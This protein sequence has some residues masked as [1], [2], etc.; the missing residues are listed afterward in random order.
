MVSVIWAEGASTVAMALGT[1]ST[2]TRVNDGVEVSMMV[3]GDWGRFGV[4]GE[5][6]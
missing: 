5:M 6:D 4:Y 3:I 1:R 2:A